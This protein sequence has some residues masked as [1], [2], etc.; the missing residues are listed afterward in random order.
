MWNTYAFYVLYADIDEFDPTKYSLDYEKLSVMDKWMLSKLNTLIGEVDDNLANYR[1][2]ETAR[3][4]QDFV[5]EMSNWYVRRSRERFWS[6]EVTQDKINAYMTLYT[7]LVTVCK[8]VAPMIPFMTEEIYQNLVRSVDKTQ[9]ES[10]HLCDFP[11]A[12]AKY[13]DKTLEDDMETVLHIVALGRAARNE[14]NIK[15]RQPLSTMYI[16]A[17]RHPGEFYMEIIADELNVRE[18]D[19]TADMSRFST[20]SFKPQL[21]TLGPR[22]GKQLGEIK[23]LLAN[24][25]GNAAMASIRETG[26][27]VL[28]LSDGTK[29]ELG[30]DDVLVEAAKV[31]GFASMTEGGLAVALDTTLTDELVREGFVREIISKIQTM[32]KAAGFNVMDHIT[33]YSDGN[34]E[35]AKIMAECAEEIS[36]DVLADAILTGNADGYTKEWDINGETVTLTVVKK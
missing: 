36:H 17:E 5:D 13:I 24:V 23:T 16:S 27:L 28:D 2:T 31:D 25:D 15:N 4:L 30:E 22:Y 20:Y 8:L 21:K 11:V 6:K 35:I 3:A 34:A 33:V 18:V 9:P 29:A 26:K 12:D 1:I 19:Y 14:A 32:R 10:I 7:T